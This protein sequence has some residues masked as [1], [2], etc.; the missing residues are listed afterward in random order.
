LGNKRPDKRFLGINF[1]FLSLF[2]FLFVLHGVMFDRLDSARLYAMT[3]SLLVVLMAL[4]APVT[5]ISRDTATAAPDSLPETTASLVLPGLPQQQ[6][7]PVDV[8]KVIDGDTVEVRAHIWLDQ[9]VQARIRLRSIDA[10]ELKADCPQE[11]ALALAAKEHLSGLLHGGKAYLGDVGRDKYG[12]RFLG[13]LHTGTGRN[14]G[15]ALV[16]TG[17]ARLYDGRKRKSW[18]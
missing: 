10:P 1:F 17:H 18:C 16:S 11:A 3:G 15:E 9:Q 6:R 8:L 5:V 2:L 13:T 14:V 4:V 7:I 12:G